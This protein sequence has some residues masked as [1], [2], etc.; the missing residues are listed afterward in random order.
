MRIPTDLE[1]RA[2]HE[3]FAPTPEAFELVWTHC[4]IVCRIAERAVGTD[5]LDM[6]LVR[7][8][9]LLH[10]IG[11]HRLRPGDHYVRHGLL[12]Y[13]LLG[14]AG[15][16]ETLR[17]FCSHHTGVGITRDDVLTQQ[18]PLPD[19]DFLAETVEEEL[20]MFAD[21]FHSKSTPPRFLTAATFAERVGRFG[22]E[23]VKRFQTLLDRFGD[24]DLTDLSLEYGHPIT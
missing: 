16:P 7:A 18:L 19:C 10:D 6:D 15:L 22:A 20:V 2:L 5:G 3:R 1:I 9:C 21:K 11:V 24:P 4:Q 23:K 14:E 17:R 13:Q 8:G 12:G